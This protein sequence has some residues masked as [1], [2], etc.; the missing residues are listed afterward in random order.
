MRKKD[1]E[2]SE[3]TDRSVE[4]DLRLTAT[5]EPS[6]NDDDNLSSGQFTKVKNASASGLGAMGRSDEKLSDQSGNNN[7][8]TY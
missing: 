2:F 4:K 7:S 6:T 3:N 1:P 5:D 8:G